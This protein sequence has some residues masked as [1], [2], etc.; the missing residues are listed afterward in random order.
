MYNSLQHYI[1]LSIISYMKKHTTISRLAFLTIL[2]TLLLNACISPLDNQIFPTETEN[3]IVQETATPTIIWFP[4]TSTP[5]PQIIPTQ[6]PTDEKRTGLGN[7]IL[8]DTFTDRSSWNIYKN[9]NGTVAYDQHALTLSVSTPKG[10][11]F[12]YRNDTL[13]DNFY[14][15]ITSQVN[16]CLGDD[17]HGILFRTNSEYDYYRLLISCN[18]MVRLERLNNRKI[19]LLQ[20]WTPSGQVPIGS[21]VQLKIGIWAMDNEFRFFIN[22]IYQFTATDPV[23][24]QGG[25]GVFARSAGE[26]ALSVSFSDVKVYNLY[27]QINSSG[28]ET[29]TPVENAGNSSN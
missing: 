22:D 5:S 27:V 25:L 29:V 19:A 1:H 11:L 26:N 16:L 8:T 12:S 21:P 6:I 14:L 28:L 24:Q 10:Q 4:M 20:D 18:G 17:S 7:I 23:W 13:I 15:E 2:I 3:V 9:S